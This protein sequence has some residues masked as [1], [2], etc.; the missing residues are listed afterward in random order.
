MLQSA[1]S[2]I[3][4][5]AFSGSMR[6]ATAFLLLASLG[7]ATPTLVAAQDVSRRNFREGFATRAELESLAT[8]SER[9]AETAS[10][11]SEARR[12][13][14]AT[15]VVLRQRLQD[16]D[17]QPGDRIAVVLE[18]AMK[19]SDT[20]VVRSGRTIRLPDLP[21]IS[22]V[23]VLRS[24]LQNHLTRELTRYIREPQLRTRP[25]L[26][27]W[28]SGGVSRPGFYSVPADALLSDLVM[29]AGGPTQRVAFGRSTIMRGAD[30]LWNGRGVET[31]LSEG[32]TVDAMLLRS[33]DAFVVGERRQVNWMGGLAALTGLMSIAYFLKR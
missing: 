22:L 7:A 16:G 10:L 1:A 32:R 17:F 13:Q 8:E 6:L 11:S 28:I 23:G 19:F 33:G 14:A 21:E 9:A 25:L 15:A 27:L 31:A 4:H 29:A 12:T 30:E 18:G 24:E 5:D 3:S 20:I 26:R 2:E